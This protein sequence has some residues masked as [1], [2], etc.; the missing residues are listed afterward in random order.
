LVAFFE[1]GAVLI[2]D[3]GVLKEL[4]PV[5][6]SMQG[7][8]RPKFRHNGDLV[9]ATNH[10][11]QLYRGS[12]RQW[13][14]WCHPDE[15]ARNRVDEILRADNGDV[16]LGT[17]AG[18]EVR[19]ADGRISWFDEALGRDLRIITDL[20]QDDAGGIWVSS[21]A[22][23]EGAFRYFEETWQFYGPEDGM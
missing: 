21:V 18:V 19:H 23:W 4:N 8:L 13:H 7:V 16:W 5:P 14:R 17:D 2:S 10:G 3:N 22:Y 6:E 1:S 9:L 12:D 20:G 15:G 11:L